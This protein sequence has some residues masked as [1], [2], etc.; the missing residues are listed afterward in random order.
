MRSL[1]ILSTRLSIR[2]LTKAVSRPDRG[3]GIQV[4][5]P[6]ISYLPITRCTA[7]I[8][9]VCF[10]IVRATETTVE[11]SVAENSKVIKLA[12]VDS[13]DRR[14]LLWYAAFPHSTLSACR[15]D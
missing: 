4:M 12:A 14:G 2:S 5:V 8:F 13:H 1:T 11:D 9:L 15:A 7:N 3:V 6:L 10:S